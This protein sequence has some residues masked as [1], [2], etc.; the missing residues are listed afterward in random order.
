MQLGKTYF[1]FIGLIIFIFGIAFLYSRL[2]L[3]L[4]GERSVGKVVNK[5][6]RRWVDQ[7]GGGYSS[8]LVIQY[9]KESQYSEFVEQNS[10]AS[11]IYNIGDSVS[12]LSDKKFGGRIMLQNPIILFSPPLLLILLSIVPILIFYK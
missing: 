11:Y 8:N 12:L 4:R 3:F 5:V 10:I 7:Q 6:T 9:K 1:L 2:I